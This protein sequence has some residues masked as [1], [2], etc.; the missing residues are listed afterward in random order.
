MVSALKAEW[1]TVQLKSSFHPWVNFMLL[2]CSNWG[3]SWPKCQ[4]KTL[5]R[6][7]GLEQRVRKW[8]PVS[9]PAVKLTPWWIRMWCGLGYYRLDL[10]EI[11]GS[12]QIKGLVSH[13]SGLSAVPRGEWQCVSTVLLRRAPEQLETIRSLTSPLMDLYWHGVALVSGKPKGTCH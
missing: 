3:E 11:R 12:V 10:P 9:Y 13:L 1:C 5:G 2:D 8:A 6:E 7:S 4:T